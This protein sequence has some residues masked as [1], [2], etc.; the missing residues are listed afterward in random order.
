MVMA[1]RWCL[2]IS[3]RNRRS[4][5]FPSAS[6]R[7]AISSAVSMPGIG[8]QPGA[9]C[10]SMA[11][12]S[13]PRSRSQSCIISISS[14]CESSMRSAVARMAS[15]AVFGVEQPGH[16]EGLGVV[17]DHALH[18]HHVRL[19]EPNAGEV[20]GLGGRDRP[21]RLA[22]RARLHDGGLR[23]A[24]RRTERQ[25]RHAGRE[26]RGEQRVKGILSGHGVHLRRPG[27]V[28]GSGFTFYCQDCGREDI[29][30]GSPAARPVAKPL[31]PARRARADFWWIF[32]LVFGTIACRRRDERDG[33]IP[34]LL[35][36]CRT[37]DCCSS[38]SRR[39]G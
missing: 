24:R 38:L 16:L 2:I 35:E 28:R 23:Q 31:S 10:A 7:L 39:R 3:S 34:L 17:R 20:G 27:S 8:C 30:C 21:A 1:P 32:A 11:V 25:E 18:E 14:S 15:L 36:W 4:N 26:G 37:T 33:W 6:A 5:A 12:T 13:W 29:H 22:G 9:W 19:G